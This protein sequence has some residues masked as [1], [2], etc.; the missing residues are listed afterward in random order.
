MIYLDNQATTQT[1]ER[2]LEAMLPYFREQFGNPH[3][4]DHARGWAAATGLSGA[5]ARIGALIGADADEVILTSGATEAN[6]LA[7]LGTGLAGTSK[8]KRILVSAIEHKCVLGA[9]RELAEHH[10]YTVNLIPV[11]GEGIVDLDAFRAM[12]DSDVLI[13]SVMLVNNEVGSIQPIRELADAAHAA[14]VL[15]HCDAAQ[16]PLAVDPQELAEMVDL[17]SLSAHKMHGPPGIGALYV[18]RALQSAVRPLLHGGGQQNDLR[19]GTVPL[20][21]AVGFGVAADLCQGEAAREERE[22]LRLRRDR[23]VAGLRALDW[24]MQ[25]NGPAGRDRH[26]GNANIRF[27]GVDAHDLLHVLQPGV[28]ASTGSACSSAIPEPSHVLRAMGLPELS[29]SQSVRFSL[30]RFT[31]DAEVDAAIF[32]IGEALS[33][34]GTASDQVEQLKTDFAGYLGG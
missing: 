17:A 28:A 21:L 22:T 7:I 18:R 10:G 23:F 27:E 9:A 16:A 20:P 25:L 11:T 12:I 33:K 24:A 15:I 31:S 13:A 4:A 30:G 2:V 26:P 5:L 6:N 19:S 32:K 29:A 8:R 14:G 1:D 34:V 3:A